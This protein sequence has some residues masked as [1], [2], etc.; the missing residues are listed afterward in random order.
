MKGL[1][2]Q[3][4]FLWAGN[5][6]ERDL[7]QERLSVLAATRGA[8]APSAA[9]GCDPPEEIKVSLT[10]MLLTG[11][12]A[13]DIVIIVKVTINKGEVKERRLQYGRRILE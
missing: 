8:R 6:S 1:S 7:N 4:F 12:V 9:N 13:Y 10:K 5:T 11:A 3:P 2:R